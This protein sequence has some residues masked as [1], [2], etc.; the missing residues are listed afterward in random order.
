[1]C[2]WRLTKQQLPSSLMHT[3]IIPLFAPTILRTKKRV[4][5]C[6]F[7]VETRNG[8]KTVTY[9]RRGGGSR[10]GKLQPRE[11]LKIHVRANN[12]GRA[13]PDE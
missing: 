13:L 8:L 9:V 3:R 6:Q 5:Q 7:H 10:L 2:E 4:H 12:L 1:M 11:S